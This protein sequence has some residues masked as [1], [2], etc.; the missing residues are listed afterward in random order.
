MTKINKPTGFH[1]PETCTE[2]RRLK[3]LRVFTRFINIIE[4]LP[5]GNGAVPELRV[6]E[7][8][9]KGKCCN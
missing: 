3:K 8:K 9:N 7:Y 1:C 5:D 4:R 2:N 6:F